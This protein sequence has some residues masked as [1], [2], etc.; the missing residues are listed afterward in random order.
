REGE[1]GGVASGAR[2]DG[3]AVRVAGDRADLLA[4]EARTECATE[5]G[6]SLDGGLRPVEVAVLVAVGGAGESFVIQP[7]YECGR[8][9]GRQQPRR[10]SELV[11]KLDCSLE[12]PERRRLVSD[13]E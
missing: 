9:L 7:R 10:N 1:V 2:R 6:E 11:L 8:F 12:P 4:H 13:E 3:R 5:L